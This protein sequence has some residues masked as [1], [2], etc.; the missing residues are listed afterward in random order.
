[1][2]KGDKS[3]S[4]VPQI[5]LI[6]CGYW[7]KN[8]CRNFHALGALSAVVDSTEK[9]QVTSRSIAPD[10]LITDN[11]DDILIDNQI[12]GVALLP[13]PKRMPN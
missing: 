3:L 4:S 7:G 8:L 1:M 13:L 2:V 10:V 6:G 11:F 9:G 12:Q 5:A